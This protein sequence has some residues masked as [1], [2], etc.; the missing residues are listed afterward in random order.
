MSDKV[1]ID[2]QIAEV[3]REIRQRI[4]RYPEVVAKGQLKEETA[5]RKLWQLQ[6]AAA[7]LRF[8]RDNADWIRPIAEERRRQALNLDLGLDP[9]EVPSADAE[10]QPEHD[11][12]PDPLDALLSAFPG[13]TVVATRTISPEGATAL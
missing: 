4:R 7:S 1:S 11:P 12:H 9:V 3:E 10:P 2:D 8:L 5:A 13:S 6:A